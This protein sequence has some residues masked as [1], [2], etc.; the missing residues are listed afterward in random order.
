[1]P[2]H[3]PAGY[4]FLAST[5]L[6]SAA[7]TTGAISFDA[8]DLLLVQVR[9]TGY[10][11]SDIASF[12]FNTDTGAN[13]WSRYISAATGAVTLTNAQNTSQSLARLFA[14]GTTLQRSALVNIT[15]NAGTSKVGRVEGQTSS[16]AAAT[17]PVIEW[18]G[19]EWINTSAQIT[20]ITMLTA[21]GSITLGI[22]SG[23]AVFGKNLS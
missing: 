14:A 17:A 13:Y 19:F 12:R 23:F 20:S 15:N 3:S 8:R 9:V 18:G 1:M 7:Q 10:S 21:G 5:V 22:G 16:G 11:G 4:E 6:T 2:L